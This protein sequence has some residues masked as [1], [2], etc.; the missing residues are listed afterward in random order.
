M[1]G[2]NAEDDAQER[3]S[4]DYARHYERC[5][6]DATTPLQRFFIRIMTRK[7]RQIGQ[8]SHRIWSM[9]YALDHY[10]SGRDQL[11][12][13]DCGAWNGWFL[14]YETPAVRRRIALDF[15]PCH[16]ADLRGQGIDFVMADMEKGALP[17]ASESVDMLVMTSTLE[18]LS[19]PERI[20]SEIHRLLRPGGIV[21]VTVPDILK[22][23]FKFWDDVTHK[24]PFTASA[25]KFLFETHRIETVECCP[26][27]HNLFI[28]GHLFPAPIHRFLMRFRGKAIL[29]VGK[30]RAAP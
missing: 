11:C 24:R 18:H 21:F 4:M 29:Y 5:C 8:T 28:A 10:L 23:G 9:K 13:L 1:A 2:Q 25:L 12:V 17:F 26:Y 20:A 22:Y 30:K 14:S 3:L 19:C 7:A 27:N 16:A 6:L 15:D